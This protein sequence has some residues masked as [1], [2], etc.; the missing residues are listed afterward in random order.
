MKKLVFIYL[1]LSIF[2]SCS[3]QEKKPLE[4]YN[5]VIENS[6]RNQSI[7]FYY[8]NVSKKLIKKIDFTFIG[9]NEFKE[10]IKI[11][12]DS[13]SNYPKSGIGISSEV[14]KPNELAA[15]SVNINNTKVIKI[16]SAQ[17]NKVLFSDGTVWINKN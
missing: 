8:K 12:L 11:T 17:P 13:L 4:I 7:H 10:K 6:F 16:I 9:E 2:F 14:L 15:G 1:S 3:N 5:P